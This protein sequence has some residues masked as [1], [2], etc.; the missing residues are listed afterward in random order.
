[1][2]T[3][4]TVGAASSKALRSKHR[5][6]T[7]TEQIRIGSNESFSVRPGSHS[8]F[9]LWTDERG[10][11][12]TT[13]LTKKGWSNKKSG[14]WSKRRDKVLN[15]RRGIAQS[16]REK[17]YTLAGDDLI[18]GGAT[19][20]NGVSISGE[21]YTQA[22]NDTVIGNSVFQAGIYIEGRINTGRENDTI[23]ASSSMSR[24]LENQ[25]TISTEDGDHKQRHHHGRGQL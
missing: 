8:S 2:E 22:D 5:S 4:A 23:K 10:S 12:M 9:T 7:I 14:T 6:E 1:V 15:Q 3:A 13:Q 20:R 19:K 16:S 11:T 21:L 25:G 17:S 24:G 18:K